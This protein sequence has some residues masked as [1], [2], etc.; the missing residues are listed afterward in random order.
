MDADL[1]GTLRTLRDIQGV[2]GSFVLRAG[3]GHLLGRDMPALIDDQVL[4]NI[5]P[6]I[7]RLLDIV[8]SSPP[9]ESMALRFG[10]QRIDVKRIKSAHL[11]VLADATVSAPAL[12]MAMRLVDRKLESYPWAASNAAA[13]SSP[14]GTRTVQ[15]RGGRTSL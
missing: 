7:D 5:G 4:A 11:C 8:E 9:T 14:P 15:F 6:R 12:R 10:E 13:P 2:Q 1:V 3:D